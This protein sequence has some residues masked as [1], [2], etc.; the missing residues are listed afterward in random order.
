[1]I[2]LLF[3]TR[4]R[5]GVT[6]RCLRSL[7]STLLRDDVEWILIN[8]GGTDGTAEWLLKVARRY[9][10]KVRVV[11][12]A[13]NTGVAGGRQL[14]L[15][16]ARGDTL[17]FLDNDVEAFVPDWLERVTA[18]LADKSVGLAGPGGHWLTPDWQWYTP[19]RH[20]YV[21]PSDVVS[22]YCQA[23][24]RDAIEGFKMD[25]RFNPYWHED[26]DMCLWLKSWGY[27]V[28]CTGDIGVRHIF[29]GT[30]ARTSD[31]AAKQAHLAKKW[32]GKGLVRAEQQV[33]AIS[34]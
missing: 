8:N 6:A 23:F 18:P 17:L 21:G 3:L 2:S 16:M 25:M 33:E 9:P 5:F 32:R 29:A 19:V 14:L 26:S 20:D 34:T 22:G 7:A 4:N 13:D 27:T 12:R 1:V 24:R 10:D 31:G 15:D 11:L 28:Y 30:G